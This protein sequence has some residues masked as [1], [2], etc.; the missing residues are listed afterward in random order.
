MKIQVVKKGTKNA[1]PQNWCP[2]YIDDD[3]GGGN[4]TR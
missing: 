4:P 3:G 1:K 2:T